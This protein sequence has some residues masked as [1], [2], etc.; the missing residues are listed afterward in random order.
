M[1]KG[2]NQVK[3]FLRRKEAQEVTNNEL[4]SISAF[5]LFDLQFGD[6]QTLGEN[7]A[8]NSIDLIFTDPPYNEVSL[9]LYGDLAKLADRV[10]KP[11]G[12]LV[13]YVGHYALFKINELIQSYSELVYHWQI[14]VRH[15]GSKTRIHARRIWP[16]YK[17]LLWY[18]K[19]TIDGKITIYE[20]VVDL[21]ESKPVSKDTHKWE[22]STIE[23]EHMIKPLTVEANLVIRSIYGKWNNW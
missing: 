13:T 7:I 21:I 4:K 5:E 19:P 2:Y 6:M 1:D 9:A 3:K 14:I 11:G 12:S 17:P 10:L 15:S 8:D 22:Q 16:H 23:A 18:Y 20:D